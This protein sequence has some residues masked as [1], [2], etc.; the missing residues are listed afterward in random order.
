MLNLLKSGGQRKALFGILNDTGHARDNFQKMFV[1]TLCPL[2]EQIVIWRLRGKDG[3]VRLFQQEIFDMCQKQI[4]NIF[5]SCNR[6]DNFNG[7][8]L[9]KSADNSISMNEREIAR[10]ETKH[11]ILRWIKKAKKKHCWQ[12]ARE[13][14]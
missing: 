12:I 5:E 9:M 8:E 13:I 3:F 14:A 1:S 10:G 7:D 6:G 4:T 11:G 2:F